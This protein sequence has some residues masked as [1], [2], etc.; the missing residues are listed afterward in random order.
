M[1]RPLRIQYPGAAYHVTCRGNDRRDIFRDDD[2]CRTFQHILSQSLNIYSVNLHAYVQMDNHF[3]LLVETPLGNLSDFMRHFNIT[4]TGYFNRRH[5][6]IG[7]LYQ[8]RYKSLLVEKEAHRSTLSRY[9]HLNPIRVAQLE[10]SSHKQ[11]VEHLLHYP[12]SSLAGYLDKRKRDEMI[13][14]DLVLAEYGGDTSKGRGAYRKQFF[15]DIDEDLDV[16]S[17]IFG[18]SIIGRDD[19]IDW[20]KETFLEARKTREQPSAEKI[21]QL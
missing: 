11:K 21:K 19:F 13:D 7:H 12:W 5:S 16:R 1:A 9:I 2:D 15:A 14:H 6:R 17:D 10:T 18:Q 4:Y 8:G 3:H 20:V